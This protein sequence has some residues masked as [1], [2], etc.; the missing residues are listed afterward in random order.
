MLDIEQEVEGEGVLVLRLRGALTVE[1]VEMVQKALLLGLNDY[2]QVKV[3]G[4][5]LEEVDFFG[6]QLLC[7]AHRTSIA[8]LKSLVWKD[9]MPEAVRTTAEKIGFARKQGCTLCPDDVDCMWLC[10]SVSSL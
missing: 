4:H 1:T 3:D 8:W 10:D 2:N 9:G 6:V 7:S 5:G